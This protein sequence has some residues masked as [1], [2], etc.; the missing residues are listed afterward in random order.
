[1]GNS[2][3]LM[4]V[5]RLL[6]RSLSFLVCLFQD[7]AGRTVLSEGRRSGRILRHGSTPSLPSEVGGKASDRWLPELL[8]EGIMFRFHLIAL[9]CGFGLL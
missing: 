9:S 8:V 1:M 6:F 4:R 3:F 7:S 2:E 5:S